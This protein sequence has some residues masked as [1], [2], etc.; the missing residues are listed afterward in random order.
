VT[1]SGPANYTSPQPSE[2]KG[3]FDGDKDIDFD[4]F[5]EFAAAYDSS[6]GDPNY[7][8][9]GDF[10]DDGNVDFDDFVEFAAVYD[11]SCP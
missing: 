11:T 8:A 4:D 10:D 2:C 3:D 9:A 6:L 5:V 7:D 1:T